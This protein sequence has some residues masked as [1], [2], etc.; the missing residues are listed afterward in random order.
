[1]TSPLRTRPDDGTRD[2]GME[3]LRR[4]AGGRGTFARLEADAARG[5]VV[6]YLPAEDEATGTQER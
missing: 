3:G 1:M 2:D 6:V 5:R 4:T